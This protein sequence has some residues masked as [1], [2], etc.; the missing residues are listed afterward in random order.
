MVWVLL[1]PIYRGKKLRF[2]IFK[3]APGI[4]QLASGVSAR[5]WD[6]LSPESFPFHVD[7]SN[8]EIQTWQ[9]IGVCE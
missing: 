7:E 5:I 4:T 9:C 3:T 2:N 8:E 6:S 1:S